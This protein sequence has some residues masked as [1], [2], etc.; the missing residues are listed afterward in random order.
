MR[1]AIVTHRF[2]KGEGQGRVNYE[3]ARAAADAGHDVLCVAHEVAEALLDHPNVTHVPMPSGVAPI[4]LLGNVR[5]AWASHRWLAN[6]RDEL[7]LV[8]SNG[9]NTTFPAD[10]SAVHFV[11][12]AWRTSPVHSSR[13]ESGLQAWYQWL[14]STIN[15]LWEAWALPR[16]DSIV[17]VS[18]K[19]R[20]EL[21][22][23]GIPP[24]TISVIHNG[25][26][27]EEFAPGPANRN[28]LG[29]PPDVPLGLFAGGIETPRKN[30]DTVLRAMVRVP[31]MHLAVLAPTEG[32]PY[33][34]LAAQLGLQDRTH[35]LGFRSDVADLMRASD[36]LA[37]PSRYE[38]C[39]LVLLE[40]LGSG[41]PIVTAETAGGAELVTD[42]CGIVLRDPNDVSALA[43]AFTQLCANPD[44]RAEM[45]TAAR[46]VAEQNSWHHMA[47]RY[48][49][50]F[51]TVANRSSTSPQPTE[52]PNPSP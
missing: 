6:H 36:F 34:D 48:L 24:D 39:S 52:S 4:A 28:T 33:P 15:A 5:F 29:L 41:L 16:I 42:D 11:H 44:R 12:S 46:A 20:Q 3:V 21:I 49:D 25:V 7:D 45:G 8:V 1:I 27:L 22:A 47:Q 10:V 13:S 2:A 26:D 14:Y 32:S 31:D 51:E 18:A 43:D 19:V 30:I 38:A 9:C 23:I 35:F 50:L 40:A 37:F 17:A